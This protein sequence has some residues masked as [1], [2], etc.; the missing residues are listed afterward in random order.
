[1]AN[2]SGLDHPAKWLKR[3]KAF[4]IRRRKEEL[5][6]FEAASQKKAGKPTLLFRGKA[7]ESNPEWPAA[8]NKIRSSQLAETH[9]VTASLSAEESYLIPLEL[10]IKNKAKATRILPGLLDLQLPYSID[11]TSYCF[12]EF[13]HQSGETSSCALGA[14]DVEI[15]KALEAL[16]LQGIEVEALD[17]ELFACWQYFTQR[18]NNKAP[19]IL[20]LVEDNHIQLI[21]GKNQQP[22][23]SAHIVLDPANIDQ[24][25]RALRRTLKSS[26]EKLNSEDTS[27]SVYL[28]EN[29]PYK[30]EIQ[31]SLDRLTVKHTL[32]SGVLYFISSALAQRALVAQEDSF[33]LLPASRRPASIDK[34]IARSS[35]GAAM[36]VGFSGLFLCAIS[37]AWSY[38]VSAEDQALQ[39]KLITKAQA[40]S[41]YDKIYKGKELRMVQQSLSEAVKKQSPFTQLFEA[42]LLEPLSSILQRCKDTD[43][44]LKKVKLSNK[45]LEIN[46]LSKGLQGA[47]ALKELAIDLGY[48]ASIKNQE[49]SRDGLKV[50]QIK[51]SSSSYSAEGDYE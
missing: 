36:A 23:L 38:V 11:D 41:G 45:H 46:S 9:I 17:H 6:I 4:L 2:V 5:Q 47:E 8:K 50:Y 16:E 18:E 29:H 37:V 42:S 30:A 22:S 44:K 1:V 15:S 49:E 48:N 12:T 40:M 3:K 27:L 14:R 10:P 19:K 26:I 25:F 13:R 35:I 21:A 32:R 34:K 33:S 7:A 43:S 28:D 39:H 31:Q 24:N 20:V 51:G